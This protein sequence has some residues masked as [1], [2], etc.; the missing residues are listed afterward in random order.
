MIK[1]ADENDWLMTASCE[2]RK[3][4]LRNSHAY[5]MLGVLEL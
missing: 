5:T 4:G 3:F 1:E 2:W